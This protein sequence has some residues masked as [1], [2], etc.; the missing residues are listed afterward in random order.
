MK[1]NNQALLSVLILAVAAVVAMAF[2][3]GGRSMMT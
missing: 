1:R 2:L 3:M